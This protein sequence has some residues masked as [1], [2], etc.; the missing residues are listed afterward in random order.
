LVCFADLAPTILSLAGVAAPDWMQGQAFA[1]RFQAPPPAFVHGFRGRMDES[2]DMIR[3]VTDG[4][5]VYL[6]NYMPHLS[7]GQH[8]DTQF[9][10][11]TT[12]VWRRLYDEG[13]LNA[14]Q[15]TFWQTPKA[16]EELYDL[17]TDPD[18]VRNL[19]A[20]PAHRAVLEKLRTAQQNHARKIRDVGFLPEGEIHAR[21]KGS[22][23]YDIGHD[24]ARYPFERIFAMAELASLMKPEAVS[25]L[26]EA[27]TDPDR[28]VRY[29]AV[30]GFLM[31]GEG[32][33]RPATAELKRAQNDD[34]PYVRIAAAWALA[35]HGEGADA[36][37][38][39][40]K[41]GEH[42]AW[43]KNDV[44]TTLAA[45]TVIDHLGMKALPLRDAVKSWPA[46]GLSPD[47][48]YNTYVP[49]LLQ[50][51]AARIS[52]DTAPAAAK[53]KKRKG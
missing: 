10:M 44:F 45:L 1:G 3:S 29:W 32:A 7:H 37:A 5:Y 18:E 50:S 40:M 11:A 12:A 2:Y 43:G 42:A 20:D 33:V 52:P 47:E 19:A 16:P 53:K 23:P 35:E 31:R 21:S 38:A 39:I 28:A 30:M 26:R 27:M 48:R 34:S 13:K 9:Q 25:R 24:D 51:I 8:V 41:L 6:R 22:T 4:R 36:N 49:R 17:Q 46:T 15:K 14:A